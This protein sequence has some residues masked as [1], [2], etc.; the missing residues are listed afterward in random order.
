MIGRLSRP[1]AERRE[2]RRVLAE[3]RRFG[4]PDG[5]TPGQPASSRPLLEARGLRKRF[6]GLVAVDGVSLQVHRGSIHALIGPNDAGKTT[7]LD[8]LTGVLAPDEGEVFLEGMDVTGIS[9]WRLAKLGIGRSFQH[10]NLFWALSP[11]E[12]VRLAKAVSAG[13]TRRPYGAIPVE[14]DA[15]SRVLLSRVGLGGLH[16]ELSAA[17]LSYGDQHSLELA[18][19][20]ASRPHLLL[21]DEPTAGL[22]PRETK[23]AVE[24]IRRLVREEDLTLLFVEHD[25]DVVF[26]IADWITVMHQGKVLAEGRPLEIPGNP[27]V[28]RAYLGDLAVGLS[29]SG[30]DARPPRR[31]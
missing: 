19:A 15:E 13:A 16:P 9:P 31:L 17:D 2:R 11:P 14:L 3:R 4:P 18:T 20:L 29:S 5:W 7:L 27:E 24:L 8:L 30:V 21:L 28:R 23:D 26:G 12:N 6:D 25:M 10:T 1:V 22:S